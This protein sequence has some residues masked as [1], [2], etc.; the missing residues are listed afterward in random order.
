MTKTS[1]EILSAIDP[2]FK[3]LTNPVAVVEALEKA[4]EKFNI[5]S[6]N[7]RAAF[8]A[9]CAHESAGF[10]ATKENLNYSAASLLKV[11]PKYFKDAN[12]AA[13]YERNPK[14]IANKVYADRMGNGPESS[15]DGY[16]YRGR[17]FIQLTGKTNYIA[18]SKGIDVDLLK[19]PEYLETPEGA[20]MSAGWYWATNGLNALADADD[21]KA[22]TKRINGGYIGLEERTHHYEKAKELLNG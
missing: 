6:L 10:T 13:A 22:I 7:A 11:F 14:A 19:T 4:M 1:I 5:T 17:G 20:A 16:T 9:Q 2:R 18:C 3:K 21:I 8:I 12:I 15:G